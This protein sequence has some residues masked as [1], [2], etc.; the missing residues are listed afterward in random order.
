M[1]GD[2][3]LTFARATIIQY[4]FGLN[5]HAWLLD[6]EA[7]VKSQYCGALESERQGELAYLKR[8]KTD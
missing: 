7:A 5:V 6:V 8:H 3:R 2:C 4:D 1:R